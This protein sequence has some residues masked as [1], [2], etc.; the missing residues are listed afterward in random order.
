MMMKKPMFLPLPVC[1][2]GS[3]INDHTMTTPITNIFP[4]SINK[5]NASI[6]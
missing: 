3:L 5:I 6:D 4:H 2:S 1:D